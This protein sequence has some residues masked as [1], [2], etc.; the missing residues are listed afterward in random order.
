MVLEFF[1]N[2]LF[3]I[4]G[5][6]ISLLPDFSFLD[7]LAQYDLTIF[8]YYLSYAFVFFPYDIFVFVIANI[9]FWLNIQLIWSIIVWIYIK[10]PGVN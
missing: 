1:F 9:L 4:F 5:F 7:P 8:F 2:L 6:A 10:I 3:R